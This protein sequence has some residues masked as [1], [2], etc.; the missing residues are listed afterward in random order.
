MSRL[1]RIV[2]FGLSFLATIAGL[3]LY[4]QIAEIQ[5]PMETYMDARMGPVFIPNKRIIR[6]SEGFFMGSVN[7]YGYMGPSVPPRRI[8]LERRILLL[9][10]S[11]I[12]GHT[13]LPRHH[14]ARYLEEELSRMTGKDIR[15]LNFGRPDSSLENMYQYYMDFAGTFDHDLALFFLAQRDLMPWAQSAAFLSPAVHLQENKVV[16][17]RDFRFSASFRL[18][19]F[20]EPLFTRSAVLRLTFNASQIIYT[21]QWKNVVLD[22]FSSL[23]S[24]DNENP[25]HGDPRIK[26]LPELK[27]AILHELARDPRNVLVIQ[28]PI[29]PGMLAEI[30]ASG[31]PV[32]DLG[33]FLEQQRSHGQDPYYWPVTGMRGHWN[34]AAHPL[35]GRFLAIQIGNSNLLKKD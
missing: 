6:F 25:E 8:G 11:F 10:D 15:A 31:M 27:R 16:I 30:V 24:R 26:E 3:D 28:S 13:V 2:L 32:I 19:K 22:K 1:K 9:G 4:F 23:I 5:T 14:F 12:L 17:N 35:I 33:S 7:E 29:A 34:H 20:I 18:S 21:G